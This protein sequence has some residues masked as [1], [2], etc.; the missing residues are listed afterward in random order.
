MIPRLLFWYCG[1]GCAKA[2]LK[3]LCQRFL[4]PDSDASFSARAWF[5]GLRFGAFPWALEAMK[6]PSPRTRS[7]QMKSQTRL[8][9]CHAVCMQYNALGALRIQRC[10][11]TPPR[12][13]RGIVGVVKSIIDIYIYRY[14][15]AQ[16]SS[17][18][19]FR[20]SRSWGL[21][22]RQPRNKK[23]VRD[24]SST[25][26]HYC[27]V[28]NCPKHS[29]VICGRPGCTLEGSCQAKVSMYTLT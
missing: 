10:C 8:P 26:E 28:Y 19:T 17:L 24:V 11:P 16:L 14:W 23:H 20:V 4:L 29:R 22:G 12:C 9:H 5:L 21:T 2:L 25:Y 27:I 18:L 7:K 1:S 6:N 3:T 13:L 15:R